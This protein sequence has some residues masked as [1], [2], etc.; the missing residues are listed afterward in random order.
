MFFENTRALLVDKIQSP[1]SQIGSQQGASGEPH[2]QA[3]KA[4][5]LLCRW[6]PTTDIQSA[7]APVSFS[8]LGS[9]QHHGCHSYVP[10]S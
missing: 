10:L 8:H 9:K 1:V 7:A 4:V 5:A 6:H 2:K 3:K